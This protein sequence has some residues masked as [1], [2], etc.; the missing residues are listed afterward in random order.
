M[1]AVPPSRVKHLAL[2]SLCAASALA[3]SACGP[4]DGTAGDGKPSAESGPYPGLSGPEILNKA[5]TTT[6]KATSL[7]LK[8]TMTTADGPVRGDLAVDTKGNCA[9]TVQMGAEGTTELVRTG[10]TVY[11]RFDERML[12]SQTKGGS[13]AETRAALDTLLGKWVREKADA[14][15]AKDLA[16]FCD[17]DSYLEGFEADDT[18]AKRA[19]GST[20]DG[21]PT[22]VLRESY[23]GEK[24]TAHVAA[25]GTPYLLRFQVTGGA[26][27]ID[28]TFSEFDRP[29]PVKEQAEK[30]IV[31]LD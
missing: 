29:V 2:A 12:R 3:L 30:D 4:L 26:E 8:V 6:K 1:P 24:A 31:D 23:R 27:P 15:D 20:V 9:G 18:E 22:V 16:Q 7:R 14:Q 13:E 28:M 11:L 17:L 5:I 10:D 21:T 19:G 25:K